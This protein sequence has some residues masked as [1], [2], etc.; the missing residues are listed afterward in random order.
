MDGS[1]PLILISEGPGRVSAGARAWR[2]GSC[3]LAE[4]GSIGWEWVATVMGAELNQL[5]SGGQATLYCFAM[6]GDG[7]G[8]KGLGRG[9]E[10]G[11]GVGDIDSAVQL[12]QPA[13]CLI[14]TRTDIAHLPL[15]RI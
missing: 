10:R 11:G 1:I 8:W 12:P 6:L 14:T 3:D 7:R 13:L 2:P 15:S 5:Q 9:G 4:R